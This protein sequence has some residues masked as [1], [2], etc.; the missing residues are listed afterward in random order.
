MRGDYQP[1]A[2]HSPGSNAG[3]GLLLLVIAGGYERRTPITTL[4]ILDYTAICRRDSSFFLRK[5]EKKP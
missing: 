2:H 1:P 5:G 3:R 4:V